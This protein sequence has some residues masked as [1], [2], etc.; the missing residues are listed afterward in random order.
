MYV[1]KRT[2]DFVGKGEENR[3]SREAPRR[4]GNV[5]DAV[6]AKSHRAQRTSKTYSTK[7]IHFVKT[8]IIIYYYVSNEFGREYLRVQD[9]LK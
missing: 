2:V 9:I 4:I 6:R 8:L 5:T 3:R 1:V 7:T